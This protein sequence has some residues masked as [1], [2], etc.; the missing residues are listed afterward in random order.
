MRWPDR[1]D[2]FDY[3]VRENVNSRSRIGPRHVRERTVKI[4]VRK[5]V[6]KNV[7]SGYLRNNV[8]IDAQSVFDYASLSEKIRWRDV[9]ALP[10]VKPPWKQ[11]SLC[12]LVGGNPEIW[13]CLD[14]GTHIGL[15]RMGKHGPISTAMFHLQENGAI[16]DGNFDGV[17][18][19]G[20]EREINKLPFATGS[21]LS[22]D[23]DDVAEECMHALQA[24]AFFHVKGARIEDA[25]PYALG[26]QSG[27]SRRILYDHKVL[28]VDQIE[29]ALRQH[30]N[31]LAG[32]ARLHLVR[33]HF[34]DYREKG[35]GGNLG[36]RGIYWWQPHIRGD[37]SLGM[38]DKEY[39][40]GEPA[41]AAG[42]TEFHQPESKTQSATRE[43]P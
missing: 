26:I 18:I 8:I 24:I 15:Q 25:K 38:V 5:L 14:Q 13:S 28:V 37:K 11:F 4:S 22:A 17:D 12:A 16:L 10:S 35:V 23:K 3:C 42:N 9:L 40:T 43:S 1:A 30:R 36:A 19:L 29:N 21:R 39:A 31:A 27:S 41:Q 33:G 34:K 6:D 32:G 20:M 7:S 2:Y